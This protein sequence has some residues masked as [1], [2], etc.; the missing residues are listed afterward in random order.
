LRFPE[1]PDARAWFGR[2]PVVIWT[3]HRPSLA[4]VLPDCD[5]RDGSS[6]ARQALTLA[7]ELAREA[8]VTV[9]FRRVLTQR[10]GEP[11]TI[12]ALEPGR[13]PVDAPVSR[14]ALGRFVQQ[15][16]AA[17]DVVLEGSWP[18][19]GKLSSWCARRGIPAIPVVDLLRSGS[20]LPSLPAARPWLAF[21][22]A[23]RHLRRAPV[24]VA[25]TESLKRTVVGRWRVDPD[26]IVVGGQALDPALFTPAD[27]AAARHRLGLAPDHTILLAG[28]GTDRAGADLG[29]VIEAIQRAGDPELRLHVFG[30]GGRL[31]ALRRLAGPA[32]P[33]AFHE[34]VADAVLATYLAAADLAVSVDQQA[35]P[36]FTV[37][38]AL[39]AG[40]PVVVAAGRPAPSAGGQTAGFVV[41]HDT[42]AWIGF[43]QRDCPSRKTLRAMG[44]AAATG[45]RSE[46]GRVADRY[47]GAVEQVVPHRSDRSALV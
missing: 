21:A 24:V 8:S 27:Q 25:A 13:R 41:T 34:P 42:L 35:D 30:D 20:W 45:A 26:R 6:H 15:Q 14:R 40:R 18:M 5:L 28:D 44:M 39:G 23:G 2:C 11:F 17:F 38:E 16:A 10:D 29:P 4:Y 9:V 46:A 31:A 43:L 1:Q 32:G 3:D 37:A 36:A 7:R 19:T 33:V 47:L 12:A 22:S